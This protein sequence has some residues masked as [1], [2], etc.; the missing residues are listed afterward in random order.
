MKR[1]REKQYEEPIGAEREVYPAQQAAEKRSTVVILSSSG[2]SRPARRP[3]TLHVSCQL[4]LATRH[5]FL[6]AFSCVFNNIT[7]FFLLSYLFSSTSRVIPFMPHLFSIT[8]RLRTY[9][10]HAYPLPAR[11]DLTTYLNSIG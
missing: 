6:N 9:E 3:W 7:G 8:F 4:S 5:C 10:R 11:C 1:F 2:G